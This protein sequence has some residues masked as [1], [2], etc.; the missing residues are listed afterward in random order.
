MAE[1]VEASA[2]YH[3]AMEEQDSTRMAEGKS[4]MRIKCNIFKIYF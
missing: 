1:Q 4:D 2:M 3:S